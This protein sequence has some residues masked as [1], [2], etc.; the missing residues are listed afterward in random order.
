MC[1]VID[2]ISLGEFV[3]GVSYR[4]PAQ[5]HQADPALRRELAAAS[6]S[7]APALMG[8]FSQPETCWRENTAG[9]KQASRRFLENFDDNFLTEMRKEPK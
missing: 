1:W 3:V 8:D 2:K 4:S 6:H 7:Q 5:E 9:H